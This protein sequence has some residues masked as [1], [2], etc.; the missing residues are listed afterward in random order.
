MYDMAGMA[1][2][3]EYTP[4]SS[5]GRVP[6]ADITQYFL[7]DELTKLASFISGAPP[8]LLHDIMSAT[9]E[10]KLRILLAKFSPMDPLFQPSVSM[11][12]TC[13]RITRWLVTSSEIYAISKDVIPYALF[14][15]L[16]VRIPNSCTNKLPTHIETARFGV[17]VKI[18]Y[19]NLCDGTMW[20]ETLESLL[21]MPFDYI[22]YVEL[23]FLKDLDWKSWVRELDFTEFFGR[24]KIVWDVLLDYDDET[25]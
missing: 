3:L 20:P 14:L 4:R 7:G 25:F 19:G 15:F 17:A 2:A 6:T 23:E 18:A 22:Q 11:Q 13:A 10:T 24:F 21:G 1:S 9:S 12:A 8:N 16:K 5:P